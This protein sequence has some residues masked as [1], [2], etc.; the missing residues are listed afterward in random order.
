MPLREREKSVNASNSSKIKTD[1][2]LTEVKCKIIIKQERMTL[3]HSVVLQVKGNEIKLVS[4]IYC[5]H[6]LQTSKNK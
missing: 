3:R 5:F 2:S 4:V 6:K 1:K